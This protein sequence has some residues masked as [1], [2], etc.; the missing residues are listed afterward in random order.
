MNTLKRRL[1]ILTTILFCFLFT[2]NSCYYSS[3]SCN[4]LL[5]KAML[6]QYDIIIIPGYPL[7]DGKWSPSLKARIYWSKYLYDKGITKNVMYSGNAVYTPYYEGKVMAL[8]AEAIGIPKEHIYTELLADHSTENVYYSYKKAKKLGF[9]HIALATDPFQT[10]MLQK[11]VFK[12]VDP[13][14]GMIPIVFD[15]LKAMEPMMIDPVIDFSS[16]YVKNFVPLPERK[17]YWQRLRGSRGQDMDTN[18]YN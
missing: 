6:E 13:N 2:L 12:K 3:R 14:I 1:F 10:K 18:A 5:K 16:A 8:Y 7:E 17:S 4:E 15:T 11:F 9:K